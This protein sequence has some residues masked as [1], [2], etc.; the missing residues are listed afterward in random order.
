MS[1]IN[2][3]F[4]GFLTTII[5]TQSPYHTWE[6]TLILI[7]IIINHH[8]LSY[9]DRKNVSNLSLDFMGCYNVKNTLNLSWKV[10]CTLK[11]LWWSFTH[12]YYLKMK[13]YFHLM[14]IQPVTWWHVFYIRS[15]ISS[16]PY[17]INYY[18]IFLIQYFMSPQLLFIH[19]KLPNLPL[20]HHYF[21]HHYQTHIFT[22]INV[23]INN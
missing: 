5:C 22:T 19:Y 18:I 20:N 23:N 10:D 6:L 7:Y 8:V 14:H 15:T 1:N 2:L 3:H 17:Y 11:L 9:T 16:C 4:L 13:I 12:L 21:Q